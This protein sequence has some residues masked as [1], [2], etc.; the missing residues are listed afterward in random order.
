M[1]AY[2][3]GGQSSSSLARPEDR[4]RCMYL[5]EISD[6][7]L[8]DGPWHSGGKHGQHQPCAREVHYDVNPESPFHP[9]YRP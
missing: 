2:Q 7:A 6:I 1:L 8:R 3:F 5:D 9:R 4:W